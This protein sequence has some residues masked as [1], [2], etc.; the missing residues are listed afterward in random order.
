MNE[1][2]RRMI[3]ETERWER[4]KRS[5]EV[6]GADRQDDESDSEPVPAAPLT[7]EELK[8]LLSKRNKE[9]KNV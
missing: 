8:S 5:R 6:S 4:A 3:Q 1:F 9:T 7:R 2:E